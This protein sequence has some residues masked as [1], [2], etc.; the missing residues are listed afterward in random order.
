MRN[1]IALHAAAFL[2]PAL[3]TAGC[4]SSAPSEDVGHTTQG[5]ASGDIYNFGAIA[6]PGSCMDAQGG[7]TG[8]GTQIQEWTC[9]GTGAQSYELEDAGTAASTS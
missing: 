2:A 8:D 1:P 6:H 9:N 3:L 4:G 7:G 5:V